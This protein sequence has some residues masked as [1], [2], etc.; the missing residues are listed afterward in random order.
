MIWTWTHTATLAWRKSKSPVRSFRVSEALHDDNTTNPADA[1][2][3]VIGG[4]I[5]GCSAAYHLAALGAK[6]VLLLDRANLS[7]GTTWHSTGNMETYRDDPLIFS[8]VRYAVESLPRL[9][10]ESGQSIGWRNVGRVMY[11]DRE[12]RMELFKTLPELGRVR[13]IAIELLSR[14]EIATRLPILETAGLLG[15][16]WVPSDGRVNP[17]DAVMAYAKAA[18]ARGVR[19]RQHLADLLRMRRTD[20]RQ[21]VQRTSGR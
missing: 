7:S 17:T 19:I 4:G 13:G 8:M 10:A 6:D 2:I 9:E 11:T 14:G 1:E 16:I 5:G 21:S 15:G 20:R 3:I 18:R 12:D